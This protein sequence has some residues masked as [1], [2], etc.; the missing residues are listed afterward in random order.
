MNFNDLIGLARLTF[1]NPAQAV[2]TLQA[3]DLPLAARWMALAVSVLLSTVLMVLI[4]KARPDSVLP[5]LRDVPMQPVA[6]VLLQLAA[7]GIGSWLLTVMGRAVGGQ[8]DFADVLL[9]VAWIELLLLSAQTVQAV[10]LLV[11]PL[12]SSLLG[13]VA[14]AA[15][16]WVSVQLL[17]AVHG[18]ANP[19]VVILGLVAAFMLTVFFLSILAAVF[20]LIPEIPAEVQS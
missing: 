18:I 10:V 17:R 8:A 12:L 14:T 4:I 7:L 11:S 3:L 16:A 19:L 15:I 2:R 6:Y 5:I 13:L 1:R 9:V 20:G